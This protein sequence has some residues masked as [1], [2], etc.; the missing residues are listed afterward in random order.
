[1]TTGY[2]ISSNTNYMQVNE[3][4]AFTMMRG[5]TTICGAKTRSG[6]CCNNLPMRNGR[7]RLHG[8]KSTG[9][10]N[11]AKLIGNQNAAGNK[12]AVTTGEYETIT[13]E[14]LTTQEQDWLRELYQLKPSEILNFPLEMEFIREARML[15]R[16]NELDKHMTSNFDGIIQLE[17]ALTRVQGKVSR[18]ITELAIGK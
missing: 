6:R 12:A 9:P 10:K 3:R 4:K 11:P 8:G 14:T 18:M 7:C 5:Q 2:P 1:M 13:W 15:G 16:M 17:S